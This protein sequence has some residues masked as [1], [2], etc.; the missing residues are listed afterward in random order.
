MTLLTPLGLLG[1]ISIIVL[2]IIY[3]IK[4]NYQQKF[5]SSTYVWK[6]SLNYRK[7]RIPT[8]NLRNFLIIL[9][10]ILI[11]TS[12][13]LILAQP[14]QLLKTQ[15]KDREVIAVIDSS[16]SMR[17]ESG[18]STRFE[19]AVYK[20][21]DL[22]DSL[23]ESDIVSVIIADEDPSFLV[24]RTSNEN[25]EDTINKLRELTVGETACSY[26]SSDIDASISLCE[27]IINENPNAQV[28]LYTDMSFTNQV[29][30]INVI[31]VAED[32]E[33][34]AS[35][36]NA[37]T[38]VVEGYFS[39]IFDVACYNRDEIIN[40]NIEIY[41]ANPE[42]DDEKG[43]DMPQFSIPVECNGDKTQRIILKN[44]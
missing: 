31:S 39:I 21:I 2:I 7:K 17:A 44:G 4:P 16:A 11:L 25:K 24:E 10:Q 15:I 38:E 32:A 27:E 43:Y 29:E 41:G 8:S 36:L 18:N 23:S 9:C 22:A 19:K 5:I 12:L 1:L 3:I 33:W 42:I 37:E 34:N 28:Y 30:G 35:I 26:A 6:L 14:N 13:S 40:V 20:V